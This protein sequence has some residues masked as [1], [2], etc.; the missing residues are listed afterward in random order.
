MK[1]WKLVRGTKAKRYKNGLKQGFDVNLK[2]LLPKQKL[3]FK[4]QRH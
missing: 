1:L 3:E 2:P 4:P